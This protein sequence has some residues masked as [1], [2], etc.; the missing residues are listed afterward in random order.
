[1]FGGVK[2]PRA[3]VLIN[4]EVGAEDKLREKLKNVENVVEA[5]SVYVE[6]D[7][8][9]KVEADTMDKLKEAVHRKIRSLDEVQSTLT[10]IV[11]KGEK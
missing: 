8:V 9:I 1:M 11:I 2:L 4:S 7:I 6:Y 5:H 3:F 10:M